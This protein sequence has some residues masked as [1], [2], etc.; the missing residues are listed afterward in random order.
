MIEACIFCWER[1]RSMRRLIWWGLIIGGIAV[2]GVGVAGPIAA[3]LKERS[4]IV[5][6]E[7]EATRGNVVA[8]VN[9]TGTV[10]PVQSVL[11]GTFVSGPIAEIRVDFN[12]E[13]KKGDLLA[14]IDPRIYAATVSRDRAYLNSQKATVERAKAQLQQARND[15]RR[16][17]ALRAEN[18]TF[19]AD[20][21]MDQFKFKRMMLEAEL[22]LAETAVA[23]A[24]ASL[25][26]SEADL[27]Y[28]NIRAPVD[29]II[30]ER[31]VEQG[32]TVAATYQTPELFT[33]AP[34]M[35]KEI[36]VY[37]SVDE[38]DI[39]QIRNAQR[40]GQPVR[41]TVDAYP[42][43]LFVGKIFQIRQNAT[44][45]QNVVTYP[46]VVS[47][48]NPELK[49]VPGMTASLS[50]QV[51]EAKDVVRIP[52][53]AL[54]FYPQKE[55]VRPEDRKLLEAATVTPSAEEQDRSDSNLSAMDK[56]DARRKRNRRH[57]WI[58]DGPLLRAV[59]VVTGLSDSKHTE[60]VSG[61]LKGGEKLV[62]GVQPKN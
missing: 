11:V 36:L 40:T 58:A 12:S 6:R 60:V 43:D 34:D 24:Q 26:K 59:E 25:E 47:A 44:T 39:G 16:S 20:S 22:S 32:Q 54:R 27:E 38:A 4:R 17:I 49:L 19:I 29:G 37:A 46:V 51:G 45:T 7:G 5:Y 61:D 28:T 3:Y 13:I 18:R 35:R 53:A 31:K 10:K 23:Q 33:V 9:S 2:V 57:V 48:P 21:E 42:D 41:F 56:A 52:N 50:F 1:F 15:E 14:K 55:Q 8:V 30:I 62:T